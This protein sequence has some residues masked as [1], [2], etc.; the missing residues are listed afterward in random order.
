MYV[1]S[2]VDTIL[3]L[4]VRVTTLGNRNAKDKHLKNL[5]ASVRE[6]SVQKVKLKVHSFS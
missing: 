4:Y 2:S 3:S 1:K 6:E 5:I